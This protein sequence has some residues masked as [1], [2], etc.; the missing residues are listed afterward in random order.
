MKV[1]LEVK[2]DKDTGFWINL[3]QWCEGDQLHMHVE[4]ANRIAPCTGAP[5]V[6]ALPYDPE[7]DGA[8]GE[9]RRAALEVSLSHSSAA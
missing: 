7:S 9:F 4:I 5:G 3:F 1:T 8:L 6:C 2:E